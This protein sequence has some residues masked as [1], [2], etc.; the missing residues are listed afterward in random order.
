MGELFSG[1]DLARAAA[2]GEISRRSLNKALLSIGL[3]TVAMPLAGRRA[4]ADAPDI[5]VFTWSGYDNQAGH[6]KFVDQY[7]A[8]PEIS[9]FADNDEGL[10]KI[11]GGFDPSLASPSNSEVPNWVRAGVIDPVAVDRLSNWADV[12]DELKADPSTLGKNGERIFVPWMWGNTSITFRTD[13]APEYVE[14]PSWNILWDEKYKGKLA[15][16]DNWNGA[17]VPAGLV[18]GLKDPF[19]PTDAEIEKIGEKIRQQRPLAKLYW[20]SDTDAVQAMASGEAA[21]MYSFNTSF[22]ALKKQGVP[23]GFMV[24]KEGLLTWCDGLVIIKNG[25]G[26]EKQ[27]Y[28]F[29]DAVLDPEAGKYNIETLSCGASNRKSFD[30]ANK[31]TVASLGLSDPQ[32]VMKAS[33]WYKPIAPDTRQ[34][35]I[36]VYNRVKGGL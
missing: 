25:K 3:A 2:G 22:A 8:S 17:A 28:D 23:V 7:G 14:H 35:L 10:A 29:L 6:K 26:T 12:F 33:L 1:R 20:S 18:L 34:K 36:E 15:L 32:A 13:M 4:S 9:I 27:K 30:L 16:R 31:E 11:R 24:P 19:N 21:A 5:S